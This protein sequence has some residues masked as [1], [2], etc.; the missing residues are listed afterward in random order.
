MAPRKDGKPRK[1]RED[2]RDDQGLLKSERSFVISY[3]KDYN[4][5]RAVAECGSF[6]SNV[7]SQRALGHQLICRP[8]VRAEIERLDR[9]K[10]EK[11]HTS[12]ED[13]ERILSE[14][15][16]LDVADIFTDTGDVRPLSEM[17]PHARRCI[18]GIEVTSTEGKDGETYTTKRVKLWDKR[19][20]TELLG[21]YRKM[22]QADSGD[23]A[24]Q[25]VTIKIDAK[26]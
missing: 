21:R 23:Q 16:H 1:I 25:V 26:G 2:V 7:V 3:L 20:A 15:A 8:H 9:I 14:L 22:F 5:T 10:R 19:A 4:A 13:V 12:A 18:S 11:L 17:P 24:P 6:T